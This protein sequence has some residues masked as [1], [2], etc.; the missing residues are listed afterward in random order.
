[1]ND[2]IN[3]LKRCSDM[4]GRDFLIIK[5]STEEEILDFIRKHPKFVTKINEEKAG[6]GFCVYVSEGADPYELLNKIREQGA[7]ILE[8]Y[9]YQHHAINEIYP[10]SVN[11]IRIHTVNN[12]KEVRCFLTPKIDVGSEGSIN[13]TQGKGYVL[14]LNNDGTVRESVYKNYEYIEKADYHKDTGKRFS[15]VKIPFMKEMYEL[16]KAAAIRCPETSYIGWDVAI[17]EDGPVIIEGNGCSGSLNTSQ[18]I[19]SIYYGHGLKKEILE[20][21][22]FAKGESDEKNLFTI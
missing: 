10:G 14:N 18:V 5:E 22:A 11:T 3:V 12:G 15:E 6:I 13:N 4:L 9:F 2:K 19:S 17:G 21:I 7:D 8:G 20:M 1:M 16:V